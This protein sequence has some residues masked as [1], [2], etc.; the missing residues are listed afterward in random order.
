MADIVKFTHEGVDYEIDRDILTLKEAAALKRF[1][2]VLPPEW[3]Q[4]MRGK[5]AL[6]DINGSADDKKNWVLLDPNKEH[7]RYEDSNVL[8]HADPEALQFFYWLG[9][10]RAGVNIKP[11]DVNVQYNMAA[12]DLRMAD[13]ALGIVG[14]DDEADPTTGPEE[15]TTP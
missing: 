15:G 10:S 2:G 7:G 12:N 9:F 14:E 5:R 1:L 8:H 6:R 13:E 3:N 4:M 11:G